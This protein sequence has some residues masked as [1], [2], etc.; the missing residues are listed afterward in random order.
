MDYQRRCI[1]A[2]GGSVTLLDE[3]GPPLNESR[4]WKCLAH[5]DGPECRHEDV[6]HPD[7]N[8]MTMLIHGWTFMKLKLGSITEKLTVIVV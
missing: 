2:G 5:T 6:V 1:H 7:P 8:G 4:M 3:I